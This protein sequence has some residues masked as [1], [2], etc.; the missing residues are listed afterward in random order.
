MCMHAGKP[1]I[2]QCVVCSVIE[3]RA[4]IWYLPQ[5]ISV[6]LRAFNGRSR[7]CFYGLLGY[8]PRKVRLTPRA[9]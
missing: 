2:K 9:L 5:A 6:L 4:K 8:A 3:V 7:V 1:P